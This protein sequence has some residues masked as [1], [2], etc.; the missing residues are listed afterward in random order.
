MSIRLA[1]YVNAKEFLPHIPHDQFP[2]AA[3]A[4]AVYI[5]GGIRGSEVGS[6]MFG[7]NAAKEL[8]RLA[9]PRRVYGSEHIEYV[10]SIFA[11]IVKR[12]NNIK[13][14][15]IIKEPQSLRHFSALLDYA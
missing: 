10:A 12:K 14:L 4:V 3:L 11:K 13:G 8:L 9:I 6:L 15:K 2:A 5:E 1:G 7:K